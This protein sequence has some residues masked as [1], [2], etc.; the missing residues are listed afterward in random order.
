MEFLADIAGFAIKIGLLGILILF[1]VAMLR[2]SRPPDL[3]QIQILDLNLHYRHIKEYMEQSLV[4]EKE[5]KAKKKQ[6]KLQRKA[7]DGEGKKRVFIVDFVGDIAA[8]EVSAL[9]EQVT[10][11]LQCATSRDEVVIRLES[12]G[13][14]VQNYG[15]AASQ[16]TRLREREIPLTVCVDKVAASGGYLM[17]CPADKILAA[18]FAIIGAVGVVVMLPNFNRLLRKLDIDYMELTAGEYKRTLSFFGEVTDKGK[19]KF[20]EEIEAVHRLFQDFLVR[21]RPELDLKSIATGES[22]HG[23]Q[24]LELHMVDELKTSDDYLLQLSE[25]ADLFLVNY[26]FPKTVKERVA[27]M[28]AE[29]A[30]R[31]LLRWWKRLEGR[32]RVRT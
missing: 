23:V 21:Y 6:L 13:G 4:P 29:S 32:S 3:G 18:P 19:A 9:R 15:L 1:V 12:S 14:M 27:S 24:A 17:A 22:W 2:R 28:I 26:E 25:D 10:A 20:Q 5:R 7:R 8:T 11:I 30:D 31:V 16:L